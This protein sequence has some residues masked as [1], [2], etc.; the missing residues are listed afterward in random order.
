MSNIT[1]EKKIGVGV[2]RPTV[3]YSGEG[4]GGASGAGMILGG[5]GI[6]YGD[7]AAIPVLFLIITMGLTCYKKQ[8]FVTMYFV[9]LTISFFVVT[10]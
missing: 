10:V 5:T 1:I 6:F 8:H 3:W 9:W 2:K 7:T 4:S